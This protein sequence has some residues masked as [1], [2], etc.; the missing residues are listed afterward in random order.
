M[1]Q[2][3]AH[4]R[5]ELADAK[6]LVD[7]IVRAQI[8]RLNLLGLPVARRQNDDRHLGPLP[9]LPDHILA[10]AVRKSEIEHDDV[11]RVGRDPLGRFRDG[12][13]AHQLVV[14]GFQCGLEEP[15]N[16][17][18]IVDDKSPD[19]VG[20]RGFSRGNVRVMRVPTAGRDRTLGGDRAP[21]RLDDAFCNG[22]PQTRSARPY[23]TW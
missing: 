13:S 20:H 15:Q 17:C 16:G 11:G 14:I 21:M 2:R 6:R 10:V 23:P 19:L 18:F 8:E 9:H 7:E 22:E 5:Q 1:A 12:P 4:A 3:G